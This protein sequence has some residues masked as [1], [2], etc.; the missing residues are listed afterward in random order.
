MSLPSVYLLPRVPRVN[1]YSV[2]F[3]SGLPQRKDY[4]RGVTGDP[5]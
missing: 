2:S 4:I 1:E 3:I 5:P